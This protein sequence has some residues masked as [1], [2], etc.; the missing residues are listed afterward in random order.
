MSTN[1]HADVATRE[2]NEGKG[3]E[4]KGNVGERRLC[5]G[6]RGPGTLLLGRAEG[7]KS[8]PVPVSLRSTAAG[9]GA[10]IRTGLCVR[11]T[12]YRSLHLTLQLPSS[13]SRKS[14]A[15]RCLHRASVSVP[16]NSVCA[17]G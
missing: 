12:T 9:P 16:R 7:D 1:E 5:S 11:S 2:G 6:M 14:Q 10:E 15:G 4:Q 17:C 8:G 13:A 3:N